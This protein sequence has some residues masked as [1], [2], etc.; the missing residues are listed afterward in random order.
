ML[1][2]GRKAISGGF[3]GWSGGV[4]G[5]TIGAAIGGG[6]NGILGQGAYSVKM[7]TI[8]SDSSQVPYM[9]SMS[10]TIRVTRREYLGDI[11]TSNTP[12]QFKIETFQINPGLSKTF[13]W[14]STIARSFSEYQILGFMAEFRSG[15]ADAL[16]STNTALGSV[17]MATQ[18]NS[19]DPLFDDKQEMV[20]SMW[21]VQ[22]KPSESMLCPIECDPAQNAFSIQYI[23]SEPITQSQNVNQYDH[24][25]LSIATQGM[26]GASVNVGEL[27]ITYDI[28]LRKPKMAEPF[29]EQMPGAYWG[30]T[31]PFNGTAVECFTNFAEVED[32]FPLTVE[33]HD[34]LIPADAPT[35]TYLLHIN[36][37]AD[38]PTT[39]SSRGDA[40]ILITGGTAVPVF[41]GASTSAWTG[42]GYSSNTYGV[43]YCF[44]RVAGTITHIGFVD[45]AMGLG[46]N[47]SG[48]LQLTPVNPEVFF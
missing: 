43:E 1:N 29:A 45:I 8:L 9:H 15:S 2:A 16:N 18:Y 13:P 47:W 37:G 24:A 35:G 10:E 39:F 32:Q 22:C 38:Y 34:I 7:N 31:A 20:N 36:W 4:G 46:V 27:W 25:R 11:I 41:A 17:V 33:N 3:D 40:S 14:L 26:Q 6:I 48:N 42:I 44:S 12:G 5:G 23:R 30:T 21:S 28:E 19:N